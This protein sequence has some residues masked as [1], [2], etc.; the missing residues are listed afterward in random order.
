[1]GSASSGGHC[2]GFYWMG[3]G[4]FMDCAYVVQV[5]GPVWCYCFMAEVLLVHPL[6]LVLV[7]KIGNEGLLSGG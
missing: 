4:C 5:N 3:Y 2:Y 1:M 7:Y 6:V